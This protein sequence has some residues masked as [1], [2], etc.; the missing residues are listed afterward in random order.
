MCVE[1]KAAPESWVSGKRGITSNHSPHRQLIWG[2]RRSR[3]YASGS[4]QFSVRT[5]P[6]ETVAGAVAKRAATSRA[7]TLGGRQPQR[8]AVST[9][10]CPVPSLEK[11]IFQVIFRHFESGEIHWPGI[12]AAAIALN[13]VR[14][15]AT[16]A[17][18]NLPTD[19]QRRFV[20]R[21]NKRAYRER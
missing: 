4:R 12:R 10:D 5:R 1:R 14:L 15:A 7:V 2:G 13:S 20:E 8:Y 11:R 17:S 21:V 16:K 9:L 18:Q 6:A 19:E 3:T